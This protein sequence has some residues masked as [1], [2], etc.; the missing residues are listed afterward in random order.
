MDPLPPSSPTISEI[1]SP[2]LQ[3][4]SSLPQD[5]KDPTINNTSATPY[6]SQNGPAINNPVPQSSAY[7]LEEP[8]LREVMLS[9]VSL[10]FYYYFSFFTATY[11]LSMFTFLFIFHPTSQSG[12]WFMQTV[13]YKQFCLHF[14]F[15]V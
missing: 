5:P 8:T 11:L 10:F 7:L 4:T 1:Q 2:T 15:I 6:S 12:L 14:Q 13:T 3:S 9:D